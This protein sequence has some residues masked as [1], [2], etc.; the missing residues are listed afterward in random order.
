MKYNRGKILWVDDEIQHLKPH[1]LFLEEKGYELF[2]VNNG[3]DAV[4]LSKTKVFDL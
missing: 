3:Q 2:Q 4:A 1:I